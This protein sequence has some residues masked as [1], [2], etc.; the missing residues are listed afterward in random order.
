MTTLATAF[1]P[2][3]TAGETAP[4]VT[5]DDIA[6]PG[7]VLVLAPHPDDE[8]LACGAAIAAAAASGRAVSVA[9][10]TDGSRSHRAS[11]SHP[12][13]RLAALRRAEVAAAVEILTGRADAM[14]W[15][16]YTDL[17]APE[18]Q[19][20]FAAVS[21]RL[22]PLSEVTAIWTTWG[23]DPHPDHLRTWELGRW[24]SARHGIALFGCPVWG[25]VETRWPLPD[26]LC[27]F[28]S[29]PWRALKAR[30][31]AA[32]V[33]QM[34]RLIDDDPEGFMMAPELARHF[35]E[36]DEIFIPT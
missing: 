3:V 28:P 5:L 16:G 33:S 15:L 1:S 13:E 36:T 14:T 23:G 24:L 35:V 8:S 32:H 10:V 31:V 11:A 18:T 9:V 27:R 17:A 26:R 4:E 34:T 30:A 25:R 12:P 22:G 2:L 20:D 7:G 29:A 19:A 21:D 6:G